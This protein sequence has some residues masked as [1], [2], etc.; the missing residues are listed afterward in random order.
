MLKR[1]MVILTGIVIVILLGAFGA[2]R[3]S[4]FAREPFQ[5]ARIARDVMAEVSDAAPS[6]AC[7]GLIAQLRPLYSNLQCKTHSTSASSASERVN[8]IVHHYRARPTNGWQIG[9]SGLTRSYRN[10]D[11]TA[12]GAATQTLFVKVTNNLVLAGYR[13]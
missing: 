3:L 4:I 2:P 10:P 6:A 12:A 5:P 7:R 9:E 1:D 11:Q 8:T 13:H